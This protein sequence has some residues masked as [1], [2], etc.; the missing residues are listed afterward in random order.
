MRLLDRTDKLISF[1]MV[2]TVFAGHI[3]LRSGVNIAMAASALA[4]VFYLVK[5]RDLYIHKVYIVFLAYIF[6]VGLFFVGT[7]DTDQTLFIK[8]CVGF[9][10]YGLVFYNF[11]KGEQERVSGIVNLYVKCSV[12]VALLGLIQIGAYFL[13]LKAVYDY[14]WLIPGYRVSVMYFNGY[15]HSILRV[16]SLLS[17]A[18]HF[19]LAV[20]PA[21]MYL[22]YRVINRDRKAY[23]GASIIGL[24]LVFTFSAIGYVGLAVAVCM[25][26]HR[27]FGATKFITTCIIVAICMTGLF[28]KVGAF[29]NR[30]LDIKRIFTEDI[31]L[32]EANVSSRTLL[33]NG[34]VTVES[35]RSSP[36]FGY[37]PGG[38]KDRYT[39]HMDEIFQRENNYTQRLNQYDG[40]SLFLRLLTET[41]IIGLGFLFM[42][43]I[44]Y[45]AGYR[46]EDLLVWGMQ[47]GI[48][49]LLILRLIREGNY[50]TCGSFFF[51]W[52][53]FYL[54]KYK[55][56]LEK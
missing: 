24:A 46:K 36:F 9:T 14:S 4:M 53:Y 7:G 28:V 40:N 32:E 3:P 18:S 43:F 48:I 5:F 47:H 35:L 26:I 49:V 10:L 2:L 34:L 56:C 1:I 8:Q 15:T 17:E 22:V 20:I 39:A 51:L 37:G 12:A 44:R 23:T 31:G 11:F 52:L 33:M 29:R 25:V 19:V 38:H 6:S 54:F 21:F 41:G 30:L 50:F 13:D 16:N 27:K 45:Y 55:S 42:F